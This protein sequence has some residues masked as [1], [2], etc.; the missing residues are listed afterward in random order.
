MKKKHLIIT[1]IVFSILLIL[2]SCNIFASGVTDE[3]K[4]SV[5][6]TQNSVKNAGNIIE[7]ATNGAANTAKNMVDDAGNKIENGMETG[8]NMMQN[9][10][11]NMTYDTT[12]NYN[13]TQTSANETASMTSN[14]WLWMILATIAIVIVALVWYY[15]SQTNNSNKNH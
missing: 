11:G 4:K 3:M 13:T 2:L 7:N 14:V 1:S 12:G 6:K 15:T 9:V 10:A 8:E 5:D